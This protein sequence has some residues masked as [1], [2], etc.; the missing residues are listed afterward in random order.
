MALGHLASEVAGELPELSAMLYSLTLLRALDEGLPEE[1]P[2]GAL[3]ALEESA[4]PEAAWCLNE[5]STWPCMDDLADPVNRA[6]S[7]LRL[8]GVEPS[9]PWKKVW[10]RAC[11]SCP[12]GA[13]AR[14]LI[15]LFD[16]EEE[17]DALAPLITD[18]YGLK[19]IAMTYGNGEEMEMVFRD[20]MSDLLIAPCSLE[21]ARS[22]ISEALQVNEERGN[23]AP[24]Q[25]FMYRPLLGDAPLPTGKRAPDLSEYEK[26][27]LQL[28]PAALKRSKKLASTSPYDFHTFTSDEAYDF[29]RNYMDSKKK[30]D[31][32]D[33]ATIKRFVKEVVPSEVP[34][35]LSRLA[36]TLEVASLAGQTDDP[37]H[38]LVAAIHRAL[39]EGTSD[40]WAIPYIVQLAGKSL[41]MIRENIQAGF[42]NQEEVNQASLDEM[43]DEDFYE[44]E[45]IPF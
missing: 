35:M 9:W 43:Y 36:Q 24:W 37:S 22:V 21:M 25:A 19:S 26:H 2:L 29:V 30:T 27:P 5:L 45:D 34:L 12:D 10:R 15:L 28:S 44:D 41:W 39:S 6:A 13:G 11:V 32:L 8:S 38:R 14:Q 42:H 18:A 16:G 17:T 4:T 40:L 23:V 1:I 20:S 3:H 7:K 33:D 31:L